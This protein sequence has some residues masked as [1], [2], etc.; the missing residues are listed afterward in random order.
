MVNKNGQVR[1]N[2]R[3]VIVDKSDKRETKNLI[4]S[5]CFIIIGIIIT[6]ATRL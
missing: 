5:Y 3:S 1:Q 6:I 4:T 2:E